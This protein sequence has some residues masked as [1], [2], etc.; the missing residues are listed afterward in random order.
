MCVCGPGLNLFLFQCLS[1]CLTLLLKVVTFPQ[2]Q[3]SLLDSVCSGD[4]FS[5]TSAIRCLGYCGFTRK[6]VLS[7]AMVLPQGCSDSRR[8][9]T[10]DLYM[11]SGSSCSFG[12]MEKKKIVKSLRKAMLYL[13]VSTWAAVLGVFPLLC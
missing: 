10:F 2:W 3:D 4:L 6:S 8:Y 1:S 12:R 5:F 11:D 9:K 7:D 13:C